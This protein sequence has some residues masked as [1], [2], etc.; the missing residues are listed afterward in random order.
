MSFSVLYLAP[1][2]LPSDPGAPFGQSKISGFFFWS[3]SNV[4]GGGPENV[5]GCGAEAC[6]RTVQRLISIRTTAAIVVSRRCFIDTDE[7]QQSI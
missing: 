6:P 4:E 3:G 1:S 2:D 5:S 7:S